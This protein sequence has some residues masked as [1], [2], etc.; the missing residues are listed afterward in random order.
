MHSLEKSHRSTD[1]D[2]VDPEHL[3][4]EAAETTW[5]DLKKCRLK[6]LKKIRTLR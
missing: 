3:D 2:Q 5:D 1:L 6:D 4:H